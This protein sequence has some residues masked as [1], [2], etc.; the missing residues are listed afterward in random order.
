M[1]VCVTLW[2]PFFTFVYLF[3]F[4]SSPNSVL[5]YVYIFMHLYSFKICSISVHW[6][7]LKWFLIIRIIF[8]CDGLTQAAIFSLSIHILGVAILCDHYWLQLDLKCSFSYD[9]AILWISLIAIIA[10]LITYRLS[11][12]T[13]YSFFIDAS[14][15]LFSTVKRLFFSANAFSFHTTK[16][17][18]ATKSFF[19]TVN[20][21][22]FQSDD[23]FKSIFH[24]IQFTDLVKMFM[25]SLIV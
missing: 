25:S 5:V 12:L 23:K 3:Q 2:V 24:G 4:F 7:G 16:R 10:Y 1:C 14:I 9:Q 20:S 15:P 19:F 18:S 21:L 11:V 17:R 8:L 6:I 13:Q 22:L